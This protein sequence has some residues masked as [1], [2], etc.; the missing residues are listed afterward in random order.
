[1]GDVFTIAPLP[2]FQQSLWLLLDGDEPLD[3]GL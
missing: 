3:P 1:M 2:T